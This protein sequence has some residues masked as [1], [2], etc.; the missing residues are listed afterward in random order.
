[1]LTDKE[2]REILPSIVSGVVEADQVQPVSFEVRLGDSFL[3]SRKK[4]WKEKRFKAGLFKLRPGAFALATTQEFVTIP[5]DI[6]AQVHGKSTLGRKGLLVHV[7]AGL[8]DPGFK[9][10]ITLELKNVSKRN[11]ILHEGMRIAQL[12]FERLSSSVAIPYGDP[13]VNSHYQGQIGTTKPW[14]SG[15]TE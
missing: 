6:V 1:M 10:T 2:I 11:I 7:T 12:T 9:G 8:L 15:R 13:R 14:D 3:L 4:R 5:N